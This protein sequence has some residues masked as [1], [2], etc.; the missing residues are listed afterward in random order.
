[1]DFRRGFR[2]EGHEIARQIRRDLELEP[3]DPVSPWALAES[4]DIPVTRLSELGIAEAQYFLSVD[5]SAFSAVTVFERRKRMIVYNDAHDPG[6]QANDV[7]HEIGHGLLQHVPRPGL[8]FF[9]C[10]NWDPMEEAEATWL[11]AAILISE[12]AALFIVQ[13]GMTLMEAA[14]RYGVSRQLVQMR[15]NLTAARKRVARMSKG[16]VRN[17]IAGARSDS[18]PRSA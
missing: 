5:S 15:L 9:G 7:A 12:E 16:S 3:H 10:R 8:S 6:R 17:A 18:K 14:K 4:L 2:S 11:G 1:M 13:S